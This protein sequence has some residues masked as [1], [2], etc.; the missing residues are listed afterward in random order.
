MLAFLHF[1]EFVSVGAD[2]LPPVTVSSDLGFRGK[3]HNLR[4]AF[5]Q[6]RASVLLI[7]AYSFMRWGKD[8]ERRREREIQR[9]RK[10][11]E[12]IFGGSL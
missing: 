6:Q 12:I 5:I 10:E 11:G 8:R 7:C 1:K 9:E 3:L 2:E 4:D